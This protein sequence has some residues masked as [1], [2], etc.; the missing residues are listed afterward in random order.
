LEHKNK[1]YS[2]FQKGCFVMN[3]KN[4][5]L[6]I[7]LA[8]ATTWGINYFLTRND[9]PGKTTG[10]VSGESFVAPEKEV[11]NK[12]LVKEIDF[13]DMQGA[14]AEVTTVEMPFYTVRFST[15]GAGL[16]SLVYKKASGLLEIDVET[17]VPAGELKKEETPFL[18]ALQDK[19]PFYYVFDGKTEDDLS[20]SL[21]YKSVDSRS[22]ITKKFVLYK[23]S[24]KIDL[25][26]TIEPRG[27]AVLEPRILFPA[28][29]LGVDKATLQASLMGVVAE[30]KEDIV[31]TVKEK[32]NPQQGW[33][34]PTLFGVENRYFV[35]VLVGDKEH[36]VQRAYYRIGEENV[37]ALLEGPAVSVATTWKLS[38]Y[39]GPKEYGMMFAV[40]E[41]LAKV[42]DYA[43][44]FSLISRFMLWVLKWLFTYLHNYGLAILVLTFLVRLVMLP[45]TMNS[46][47]SLKKRADFDKKLKYIQQKYKDDSAR[48]AEE[49]AEL[50][51]KHG[52]PGLGGCLPLLLQIPIFMALARVLG[53]TI[54]LYKAPFFG[55]IHDLS[56]PDPLYILPVMVAASMIAQAFFVDE[57]QRFTMLISALIF[58]AVAVN[59]ASGLTLYI[60]ASTLLG[61][62]QTFIV[63]RVKEAFRA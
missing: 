24:Y 38:F 22:A 8:L 59:F 29:L 33:F 15:H 13:L 16:E 23:D 45:F 28:P 55:W 44:I 1:F 34:A 49:R 37:Y 18:V 21:S 60:L 2:H 36:F 25:E 50:I 19:T 20:V 61:F 46:E 9:Q 3:F 51:K 12:P 5:L 62:A 63:R 4:L 43:G 39:C 14:Q 31:K 30:K 42:V 54:E 40:D 11:I 53:S 17:I 35:N 41:R 26:V 47:D 58:G 56:A 32:I 57:K 6:P 52:M 27:S 48:L 10:M 7:S